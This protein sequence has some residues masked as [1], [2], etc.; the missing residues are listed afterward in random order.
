MGL[1]A[2]RLLFLHLFLG[3][4]GQFP[5]QPVDLVA[6]FLLLLSEEFGLSLALRDFSFD[7]LS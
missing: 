7:D 4:E 1:L 3:F 5:D 6:V 2:N